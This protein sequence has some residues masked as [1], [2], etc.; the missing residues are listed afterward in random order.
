MSEN[1]PEVQFANL[2][3][4]A[5]AQVTNR[6]LAARGIDRKVTPQMLYSYAKKST[7]ATVP[8]S[9]PVEFVGSA[10]KAWLDQYVTGGAKAAR[11]DFDA[12]ADQFM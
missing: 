6:V 8:N 11:Q 3:P 5:A 10:F 7:I 1:T 2:T 4:Y 9:K 12:L